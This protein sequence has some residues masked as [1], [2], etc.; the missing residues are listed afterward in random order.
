MPG[1][2]ASATPLA[3]GLDVRLVQ[4]GLSDAGP[5]V[6]ADGVFGQGLLKVVKQFQ[7][8]EGLPATGVADLDLIARLTA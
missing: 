7:M 3:R 2:L 6:K 4:L 8:Q 5:D 1:G